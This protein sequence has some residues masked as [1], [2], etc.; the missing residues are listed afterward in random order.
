[1]NTPVVDTPVNIRLQRSNEL[2]GCYVQ[3]IQTLFIVLEGLTNDLSDG[4]D[5]MYDIE[6]LKKIIGEF[7]N[8]IGM[9]LNDE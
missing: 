2:V 4:T 9:L 5:K 3:H 6:K 8:I 7:E 1:M